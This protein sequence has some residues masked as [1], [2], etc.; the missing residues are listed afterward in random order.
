MGKVVLESET[1][2][3][4]EAPKSARV[5]FRSTPVQKS[6]IERAASLLGESVTSFVLSTALRDAIKVIHE[7]QVTELSVRDWAR[8]EAILEEGEAP[9]QALIDALSRYRE[10]VNSSDG[11]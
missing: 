9:N 6:I 4:E 7:F 2:L 5:E 8:F 11:F 10:E 3:S 1:L